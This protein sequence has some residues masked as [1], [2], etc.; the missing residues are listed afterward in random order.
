[1]NMKTEILMLRLILYLIPKMIRWQKSS[2]YCFPRNSIAFL[3]EYCTKFMPKNV[4]RLFVL[5]LFLLLEVNFILVIQDLKENS[6]HAVYKN[7]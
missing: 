7:F 1:M 2:S 5:K 6:L 4:C 3:V